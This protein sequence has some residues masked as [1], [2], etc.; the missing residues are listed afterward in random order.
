VAYLTI[1]VMGD[2]HASLRF[3]YLAIAA[4]FS[5][6]AMEEIAEFLMQVIAEAFLTEGASTNRPWKPLTAQWL[7]YKI[8]S[9]FDPRIGFQTG[10]LFHAFAV[11]GDPNQ[12]LEVGNTTVALSSDLPQAGPQQKHRPFA[13][14]TVADKAEMAEIVK[15]HFAEAWNRNVE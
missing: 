15:E 1:E 5:L 10:D 4:A 7:N 2:R 11:R 9:G 8:M 14:F 12:N 6:P 3:K 13:R